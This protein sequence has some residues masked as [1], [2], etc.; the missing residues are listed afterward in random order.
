MP[1]NTN[2]NGTF[3]PTLQDLISIATVDEIVPNWVQNEIVFLDQLAKE[4]ETISKMNINTIKKDQL[5]GKVF[6]ASDEASM[7]SNLARVLYRL[8]KIQASTKQ[9]CDK[10]VSEVSSNLRM[11]IPNLTAAELESTPSYPQYSKVLRLPAKASPTTSD[12]KRI[13]LKPR[14]TNQVTIKT[15]NFERDSQIVRKKLNAVPISDIRKSKNGNIVLTCPTKDSEKSAISKL[16]DENGLKI[17]KSTKVL[18]K[19]TITGIEDSNDEDIL[20]SLL[21]KNPDV[22][23]KVDEG[24]KLE[25]LFSKPGRGSSKVAVIRVDPE[26]RHT[27]KG[28]RNKVFIVLKRCTVYDRI[29]FKICYNCQAA[30]DHVSH[31]CPMKNLTICRYCAAN[32]RSSA[33]RFISQP[34]KHICY[35][36][37]HSENEKFKENCHS[38][39]SNH[40]DCPINISIMNN[41]ILNTRYDVAPPK[42]E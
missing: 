13:E 17:L 11:Q 37:S 18:P 12:G 21:E 1:D 10:I 32:H 41:V 4:R 33:C 30:G 40:I 34:E 36:C 25:F 22:K 19:M 14:Q 20:A 27:I 3:A 7:I 31:D 24:Y 9:V 6:K 2:Q 42:N 8:A 39:Y 16:E 28:L 38:H 26:I 35:N 15:V 5:L 23:A 29:H